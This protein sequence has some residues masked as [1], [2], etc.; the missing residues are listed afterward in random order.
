M[1]ACERG[2]PS[3]TTETTLLFWAS[4]AT[5]PEE[6]AEPRPLTVPVPLVLLKVTDVELSVVIRLLLASRTSAVMS[7]VAPEARFVVALVIVR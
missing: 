1:R 4:V 6:V 7:R 5:P 2:A 3:S